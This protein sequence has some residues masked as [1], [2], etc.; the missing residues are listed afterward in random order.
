MVYCSYGNSP[1]KYFSGDFTTL[2][3]YCCCFFLEIAR[4]VINS[5]I[6]DV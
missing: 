1:E 3:D 5:Q 6:F 4:R 2:V